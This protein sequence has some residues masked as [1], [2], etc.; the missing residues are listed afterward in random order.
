MADFKLVC[1]IGGCVNS[2]SNVASFRK[3]VYR[4]HK[5]KILTGQQEQIQ[6]PEEDAV[7]PELVLEN[8]NDE[9]NLV[10]CDG[11][12]QSKQKCLVRFVLH[13][14]EKLNV[15]EKAAAVV[16]EEFQ[17]ILENCIDESQ[18]L[19]TSSM[20]LITNQLID[21]CLEPMLCLTSVLKDL[22]T[23]FKQKKSF[24]EAG[25]V[26]PVEVVLGDP[27]ETAIYVPILETLKTLLMHDDVLTHILKPEPQQVGLIG[28]FSH[29]S[30]FAENIL[31]SSDRNTLQIQ[32]YIDDFQIVNPLG[33]KTKIHKIC[34]V[35]FVLGNIPARLR[36]KLFTI[37]L[38]LMVRSSYV[39]KYGYGI[40]FERALRDLKLLETEGI[41]IRTK[42][43]DI[44][45]HGTVSV[46]IADNL[47]AHELGGFFESFS[48]FRPCRFCN[49]TKNTLQQYFDETKFQ[50]RTAETYQSQIRC[51]EENLV[52]CSVYGL[53][54]NSPLNELQYFHVCWGSPSDIAHDICEGF[55]PD[56][57]KTV[58][59]HC[60]LEKYF[61]IADLNERILNF[62]YSGT[63]KTNKPT[64]ICSNSSGTSVTIKQTAM[65]CLCLLKLLPLLISHKIP[66]QDSYWVQ[67]LKFMEVLDFVCAPVL[68][69]GQIKYMGFLITAFLED[70]FSLPNVM[71]VKPKAHF[72]V[73]YESQFKR[74]GPLI[75]QTTLRFEGKHAYFKNIMTRTKNYINPC[76]TMA[77]R[78]QYLQCLHNQSESYLLENDKDFGKKASTISIEDLSESL[79]ECLKQVCNNNSIITIAKVVDTCGIKYLAGQAVVVGY[80]DSDY[81]FGKITHIVFHDQL[82]LIINKYKNT[83]FAMHL[84][85]YILHE[86]RYKKIVALN[87]LL[88]PFPISTY[89]CG[90]DDVAVMRHFVIFGY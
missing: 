29:G 20:P 79:Q 47:A 61:S 43:G 2:Y 39:K 8:Q 32:L 73:H 35:Y 54:K 62:P 22:N 11:R 52:L 25:F 46:L 65:Q 16:I 63:D 64:V 51:V 4:K 57:I 44:T 82:Y 3:H 83:G 49:A 5:C 81:E 7:V 68:S 53:K 27:K 40:L 66:H 12:Q 87:S 71:N 33:N 13:L 23:P 24:Q 41:T 45:F 69:D 90:D 21:Q 72:M 59:D 70:F 30:A 56:L 86:T 85:A 80:K 17:E 42:T 26:E 14:R 58:I 78:H 38:L 18:N 67:F 74:F 84:H 10:E 28:N 48:C 89:K 37:Q 9:L 50:L 1:G 88:S 19:M 34:A 55:G 76:R 60:I 75:N 31:F 36:S 77:M 15:S 6:C